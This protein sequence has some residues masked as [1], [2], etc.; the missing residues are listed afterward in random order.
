MRKS[1]SDR[2]PASTL[3]ALERAASQWSLAVGDEALSA[4][5]LSKRVLLPRRASLVPRRLSSPLM[6][7]ELLPI[8]LARMPCAAPPAQALLEARE[9]HS[10]LMDL[11]LIA[12]LLAAPPSPLPVA[13]FP[14]L[15]IRAGT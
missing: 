11:T 13:E 7:A 14:A 9:W 10:G 1:L 15:L 6:A 12:L 8:L 4:L 2:S 3:A 5:W